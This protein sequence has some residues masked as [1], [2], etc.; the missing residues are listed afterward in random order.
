MTLRGGIN[1]VL[2]EIFLRNDPWATSF[3]IHRTLSELEKRELAW[4]ALESA[5]SDPFQTFSWCHS[6]YSAYAGAIGAPL[7]FELRVGGESRVFLP[8]YVEGATI[9]LAGE[10]LGL[11]TEVIGDSLDSVS[12][13]LEA[14]MDWLTNEEEL[15]QFHFEAIRES[16]LLYQAIQIVEKS[17]GKSLLN[18][19]EM[20]TCGT[21]EFA[22]G[23]GGYFAGLPEDRRKTEVTTF[24]NLENVMPFSRDTVLCDFQIRVDDL[25]NAGRFHCENDLSGKENP[26]ND[27]SSFD[28]F[29][30]IAKDPDLGFRL[31]FLTCQGDLLAVE[32]GFLRADTYHVY[33]TQDEPAI[34]SLAPSRYL[35]QRRLDSLSLAGVKRIAYHGTVEGDLSTLSCNNRETLRSLQWMPER[36][37]N[38]RRRFGLQSLRHL[39]NHFRKVD[40]ESDATLAR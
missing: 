13:L 35:L 18:E 2:G 25:V 21:V 38:R 31:G 12:T 7:V 39:R 4:R 5:E 26:F 14:A 28:F 33:L 3:H 10:P 27:E 9:R 1:P 29:G 23:L 11:I 6:Y 22:G 8:C 15:L 36:V 32:F 40:H 20:T 17:E 30:R 19:S 24:Q 16:G 34:E 37:R